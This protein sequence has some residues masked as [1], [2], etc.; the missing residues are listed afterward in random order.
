[1]HQAMIR[2]VHLALAIAASL[3]LLAA[4]TLADD[5]PWEQERWSAI[6]AGSVSTEDHPFADQQWLEIQPRMDDRHASEYRRGLHLGLEENFVFS[7]Q[8]PPVGEWAPGLAF[9]IHF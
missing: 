6:Y 2:G 3:C 4:P 1:M 7:I 9:E 8:S 5:R